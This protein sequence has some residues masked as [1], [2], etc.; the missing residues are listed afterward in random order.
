MSSDDR[1]Y[2]MLPAVYR[3][4]DA[5]VGSPLRQVLAALD[6]SAR[7][8]ERDIAGLY[9]DLFVETCQ[10]RLLGFFADRVGVALQEI[11]PRVT[12]PLQA[13]SS[14]RRQVL[15]ALYERAS[16]GTLGGLER[17]ASAVTGWP[18]RA[19]EDAA[20]VVA[21]PNLR[22]PWPA[23]ALPDLRDGAGLAATGRVYAGA[24]VAALADVRRGGSH[25][26]TPV[27]PGP[28]T[29]TL[30][31]W[32]LPVAHVHR[33]PPCCVDGDVRYTMDPL[34]RDQPLAIAP[35]MR[36]P[37]VPAASDLDVPAV[38]SRV[39]MRER[40][41][42]Y[43]GSDRSVC[44]LRGRTPV[45]REE[46]IVADLDDWGEAA[47]L[48]RVLDGTTRVA[49]DPET[50]R[51]LCADGEDAALSVRYHHRRS[52]PMGAGGS[53][54]APE[55]AGLAVAVAQDAVAARD[56]GVPDAHP[57]ITAAVRAWRERGAPADVP[58]RILDSAVY[59]E[60]LRLTLQAGEHLT[61]RA[62]AGARPVL[63]PLA[64]SQS[65]RRRLQVT[66]PGQG[67]RSASLTLDGLWVA[68]HAVELRGHIE[69]VEIVACTLAPPVPAA[70]VETRGTALA[71]FGTMGRLA[72]RSSILGRLRVADQDIGVDPPTVT[73]TDSVV[74]AGNAPDTDTAI[75]GPRERPAEVVLEMARTTV[76]GE[77][78]VARIGPAGVVDSII[79]GTLRAEHRQLGE[80]R[81][82]SL[83]AESRTPRRIGCQPDGVL[84]GVADRVARGE[85]T[86]ARAVA[87]R[88]RETDRV[89]PT[90]VATGFGSPGYGRLRDDAAE[91]IRRGAA[92]EGEPGALHDQWTSRRVDDLRARLAESI[93]V[94]V[95]LAINFAD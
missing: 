91:E 5:E 71:I 67:E 35:T 39:R 40:F 77:A 56:A 47:D 36:R 58:V 79:T 49:L 75:G 61:L 93:P 28:A 2:A 87:L 22:R 23:P 69:R 18:L 19:V 45:P 82:C 83:G 4:R 48:A 46:V 32:R 52:G 6:A 9:A 24:P 21:T 88:E 59:E 7:A 1:L 63:R 41:E 65:Q 43:Y 95:D 78:S 89:R 27:G 17:V 64:A 44:L 50:G 8:L 14:R 81:F 76:F 85:V 16:K 11:G 57:S 94:G 74:D 34:G 12:D 80:V 60:D 73:I 51:F 13:T 70:P 30:T 20:W 86:A 15:D 90:F 92:D 3:I 55:P 37:G 33:A 29:V 68:D 38:I 25:R 10:D 31:L 54:R 72:V 53:G 66:G 62:A 42:E 26:S 84:R